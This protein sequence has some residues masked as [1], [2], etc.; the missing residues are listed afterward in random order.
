MN[1]FCAVL[2]GVFDKCVNNVAGLIGNGKNAVSAFNLKLNAERLKKLHC[3]RRHKARKRAAQK[4]SVLRNGSNKLVE[5][6]AAVSHVAAALSGYHDLARRALVAFGNSDVCAVF[7]RL[8]R[9][10][11][12][13]GAAA[14]DQNLF[15][16]YSLS[17]RCAVI[18][19]H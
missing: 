8:C 5:H 9:G 16:H 13:C 14:D 6:C 12:S 11:K 1:D 4:P 19:L 18:K 2:T 17:F 7:C 3:V 15:A 10:K